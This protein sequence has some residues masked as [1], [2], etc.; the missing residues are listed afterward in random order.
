M[1]CIDIVYAE[2]RLDNLLVQAH[3]LVSAHTWVV[4]VMRANG[5]KITGRRYGAIPQLQGTRVFMTKTEKIKEL[6]DLLNQGA[7]NQDEFDKL[8]LKVISEGWEA[9]PQVMPAMGS[10]G[11][12]FSVS[13]SPQRDLIE[14]RNPVT[15][16]TLRVERSSTF[17]LT[18]LFG[19]FYLAY[20]EAWLH[21]AIAL[22]LAFVTYGLSWIIYP[23]FAYR[24]IVDTY[25]RKGWVEIGGRAGTSMI[26]PST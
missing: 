25:R 24:V 12:P 9:K 10:T 15:G 7:I 20:K 21:A 13:P 2:Y 4:R 5:V 8:K 14:F 6:I 22:L 23:F 1:R 16:H 17:F 19:C 3:I 11:K 18:L 26:Q